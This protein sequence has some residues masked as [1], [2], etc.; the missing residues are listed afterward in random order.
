MEYKFAKDNKYDGLALS[1]NRGTQKQLHH[2]Q[3]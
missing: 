3:V 2:I 1:D